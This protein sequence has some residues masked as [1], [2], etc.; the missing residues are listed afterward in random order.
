MPVQY[1]E[2][3]GNALGSQLAYQKALIR[4]AEKLNSYEAA[5]QYLF[6]DD[7]LVTNMTIRHPMDEGEEYLVTLR[8]IIG[9][10]AKVAFHAGASMFELL[11]GLVNRM[12]RKSLKWKDDQYA[13]E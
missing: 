8:A 5:L 13:Q 9:G 12:R 1:E 3:P 6:D 4:F 10:R 7:I 2:V 11:E